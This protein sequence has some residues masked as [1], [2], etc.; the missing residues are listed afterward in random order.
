MDRSIIFNEIDA[1]IDT[2]CEGCLLKKHLTKDK[3][4]TAA[5]KFCITDCTIGDQLRFIGNE[6]NKFSK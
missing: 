3:G 2:Y 4:K 1:V 5:H 6:L